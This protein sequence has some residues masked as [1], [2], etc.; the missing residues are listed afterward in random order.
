MTLATIIGGKQMNAVDDELFAGLIREAM[1]PSDP[2]AR[3]IAVDE[4]EATDEPARMRPAIG[5]SLCPCGSKQ[6]AY[7]LF[8]PKGELLLYC[9]HACEKPRRA[10]LKQDGQTLTKDG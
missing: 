10:L 9:C 4:M 3:E 2:I 5:T 6:H 1:A 8:D 7:N